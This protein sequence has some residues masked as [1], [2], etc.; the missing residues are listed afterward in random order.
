MTS[1][2]VLYIR[3]ELLNLV[4]F[5]LSKIIFMQ[6]LWSREKKVADEYPLHRLI[7][8]MLMIRR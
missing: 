1:S 5:A 8:Y 4:H 6:G 2:H 7:A 3:I